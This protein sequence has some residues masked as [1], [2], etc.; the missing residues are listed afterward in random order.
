MNYITISFI[1]IDDIW[2]LWRKKLCGLRYDGFI[3]CSGWFASSDFKHSKKLLITFLVELYSCSHTIY[4]CFKTNFYLTEIM[5]FD[6]SFKFFSDFV[7]S[8]SYLTLQFSFLY[9]EKRKLKYHEFNFF[10]KDQFWFW[11]IQT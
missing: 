11:P 7:F 8:K 5:K 6:A 10:E 1:V 2:S 4:H 3:F 9:S